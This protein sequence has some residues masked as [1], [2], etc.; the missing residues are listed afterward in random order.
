MKTNEPL[1]T[2]DILADELLSA[3]IIQGSDPE[4]SVAEEE[5]QLAHRI[6]KTISS[7]RPMFRADDKDFLGKSITETINRSKRKS[8]I[9]RYSI[10]ASII[11]IL[12]VTALFRFQS[13]SEISRFASQI[14]VNPQIGFTQLLLASDQVIKI[15]TQESKIAY[16]PNGQKINIDEQGSIEQQIT[17]GAKAYNT[18]VVPYGK[19][20]KIT[21]P[22]NSTIWLNSGTKLVYPAQFASEKREVYLEGEAIFDVTPNKQQPFHVVTRQVDIKVLGTSFDLCAY[23]DDSIVSTVLVHGSVELS[24]NKSS[25]FGVS[26][27]MMTPGMLAAYNTKSKSMA[28]QN[29]DTKDFLSW[30]EGYLIM[31]KK[32]LGSIIRKLSRYYNVSIEI[33]NQEL[34]DETFSGQLDLRASAIDVLKL[35]SEAIDI[36]IEQSGQ[37]IRIKK[38][39]IS[40]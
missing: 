20:S 5:Y 34:L 35:I 2:E 32:S 13:E 24:Y 7:Q 21:L 14:K 19:R 38:K 22:D 16:S 25:I 33:E 39:H 31:E 12:G 10:A 26:K 11:V 15:E 1:K 9:I 37:S 17:S 6:Q 3:K 40:G 4:R 23:A 28:Q 18:V 8:L 36:E 29:V 27:E 30:K